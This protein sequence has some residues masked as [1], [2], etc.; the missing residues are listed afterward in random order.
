ME[1]YSIAAQVWKLSSADMCELARNSVIMSGFQHEVWLLLLTLLFFF[2]A[3][4]L[5]LGMAYSLKTTRSPKSLL[6]RDM[7]KPGVE[8]LAGWTK[9]ES[10]NWNLK[11]DVIYLVD[12]A[13]APF[14]VNVNIHVRYMLSPIRLSS[15]CLSVCDFRAPYSTSWNFWQRLFAI[16]YP[17]HPL[18]Y[19]ENFT[20][21][22]PE[23]LFRGVGVKWMRL[24]KYS[25]FGL[26]KAISRKW[27]KIGGKLVL[28]I[29]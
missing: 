22:V 29:N 7:D 20:E 9:T 6:L 16:W 11:S 3:A 15:V 10:C 23:K 25:N 18:T 19:M 14:L 12:M 26:S 24:A 27:C 2:D 21:I 8:D 1:E 13:M 17:G 5:V 28:T 4:G